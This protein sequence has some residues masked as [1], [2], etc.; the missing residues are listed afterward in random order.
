MDNKNNLDPLHFFTN[1]PLYKKIYINRD[2][3]GDL[4]KLVEYKGNIDI[5]CPDCKKERTFNHL[6]TYDFLP[7]NHFYTHFIVATSFS[8]SQDDNDSI[9]R[10]IE[11]LLKDKFYLVRFK[12]AND[13]NHI[14]VY[15]IRMYKGDL[16]KIGQY[17]SFKD[18][19]T[20][21][22]IRYKN[23]LPNDKFLDFKSAEISFSSGFGI[24]AFTY[25]RRI[26]EFLI[27]EIH[28]QKLSKPDFK[29]EEYKRKSWDKKIEQFKD[30]LPNYMVENKK[31]IY[32]ILS[33]G[34]HELSE[35]ECI[36]FYPVLK[37]S[38]EL[39]LQEKINS[40]EQT[41]IIKKNS[42]ELSNIHNKIKK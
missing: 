10:K 30:L 17:P 11:Y 7:Q 29:E 38:I 13:N 37:V 15:L 22:L 34:I 14:L 39:I 6:E 33:K 19:N 21:D 2:N 40:I 12:C 24:G 20:A 1:F 3:V 28:K 36:K 27:E 26:F 32:N 8:S 18:I 23:I 9:E 16:N 42:S 31:Y 5:Y 41:K 35:D 4:N 25:L